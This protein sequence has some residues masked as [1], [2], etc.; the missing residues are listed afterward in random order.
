MRYTA[1]MLVALAE[2][3]GVVVSERQ[4]KAWNAAGF[5]PTPT[6]EKVAGQGRG[7]APNQYPAEAVDAVLW[8]GSYRAS[9]NGEDA[10]RFWMW[11][12]GF[13]YIQVDVCAVLTASVRTLW[14]AAQKE[15]PSLPDLDA[16]GKHGLTDDAREA[17]LDE[18]DAN[19]T[20]PMRQSGQWNE[21]ETPR[22]SVGAAVLG[23]LSPSSLADSHMEWEEVN[24]HHDEPMY[25]RTLLND[26]MSEQ[27]VKR[28]QAL[29]P[30]LVQAGNFVQ[31]Y[32][33]LDKG[34]V[35]PSDLRLFW[36]MLTP[37]IAAALLSGLPQANGVVGHA[38]SRSDL[39]RLYHYEPVA[40]LL[41]WAMIRAGLEEL[42]RVPQP[43]KAETVAQAS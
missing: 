21:A 25:A 12:E 39:M 16:L 36:R 15:L 19:V 1:A 8:L 29:L 41:Q 37:E 24:D 9:L 7:R 28:T 11:L 14:R 23:I 6:R 35:I 27:D 22:A 3:K 34:M 31:V 5:L 4:I 26:S 13:D 40:V 32:R 17:L 18:F 43:E 20:H 10:T 30:T 38:R 2:A 42:R 33:L